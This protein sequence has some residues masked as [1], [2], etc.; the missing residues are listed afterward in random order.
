MGTSRVTVRALS[1]LLIVLIATAL[2]AVVGSAPRSSTR[3]SATSG[4]TAIA[5]TTARAIDHVV[6]SPL[7]APN[8]DP[9]LLTDSPVVAAPNGRLDLTL[10]SPSARDRIAPVAAGRGPPTS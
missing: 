1:G 3:T 2:L 10:D 7:H 4:H 5:P 9:A 6:A 8:L